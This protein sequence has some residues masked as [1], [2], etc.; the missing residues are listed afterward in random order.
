MVQI[1]LIV[2]IAA[3]SLLGLYIAATGNRARATAGEPWVC[4]ACSSIN[5]KGRTRC[6]KCGRKLET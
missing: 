2:A 3:I 4:P 1:G 5:G 6:Y